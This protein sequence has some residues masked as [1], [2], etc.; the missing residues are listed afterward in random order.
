MRLNASAVVRP[1]SLACLFASALVGRSFAAELLVA[2]RASNRILAFSESTGEYLRVI[3]STG[4]D[5]PSGMA[6]GPGGFLYVTNVQSGPFPGSAASVVKI[7]VQ[8]GTVTSFVEGLL[9]PGGIGYYA[10]SEPASAND[11]TLFVS[12]FGNFDGNRVFQYDATGALIRTIGTGSAMT[13]RA[14][15]AFRDGDLYVSASNLTGIGSVLKY[16][17]PDFADASQSTFVS[18]STAMLA[19][20]A[21]AGG[22]NGLEFV[23]DD[24]YVASLVGQSVI[25]YHMTAGVPDGGNGFGVPVP[26]PSAVFNGGDGNLLVS[27]LGN[28]NP[29]DPFYGPATFPG[30]ISRFHPLAGG[31]AT[32]FLNGDVTRD[33]VVDGAEALK[34]QQV[35]GAAA[36]PNPGDLDGD[37]AAGGGDFDVLAANI[38]HVGLPGAFQPTAMVR[39][40]PPT[41]DVAAIPEPTGLGLAVV[42]TLGVCSARRRTR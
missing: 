35:L 36:F 39:Y 7:D 3:A 6:F 19:I 40:V 24:L 16:E 2:D 5:G 23:G 10:P 26:Y 32:P 12:E 42:G 38:G 28:D 11:N 20:P 15:I 22:F 34:L 21:P 8:T 33:G 41:M 13:Q 31:A 4:L 17:G 1:L 18:G 27:N 30:G 9:A 37:Y 14:G 29:G 25:R